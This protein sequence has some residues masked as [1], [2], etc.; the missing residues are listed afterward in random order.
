MR[1]RGPR[2]V[3]RQVGIVFIGTGFLLLGFTVAFALYRSSHFARMLGTGVQSER[4]LAISLATGLV[5]AALLMG[6][7][8]WRSARRWKGRDRPPGMIRPGESV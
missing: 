1:Q 7:W 6:G 3:R 8:L 4:R 2:E 5:L